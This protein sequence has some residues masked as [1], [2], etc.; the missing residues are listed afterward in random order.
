MNNQGLPV[1]AVQWVESVLGDGAKVT[2]VAKMVGGI[3]AGIHRVEIEYD[4][5]LTSYVLRR[6]L[7]QEWLDK[8]PDLARHEAESLRTAFQGG[9][10]APDLIAYDEYGLQ[11]GSPVVLSSFLPGKVILQPEDM[12]DWLSGLAM[13][14]MQ[15]HQA[16]IPAFPWRYYTYNNVQELVVPSWT[17]RTED[18]EKALEI[19]RGPRPDGPE[20]FIHRDFHPTN[21]LWQNGKVSG[22]VD[23]V[24]ACWGPVGIDLGH[25]RLNLVHLY[26][27]DVADRFLSAYQNLTSGYIQHAYWDLIT[28]VEFLPGP[29]GMYPG[30]TDLG[31][32]DIPEKI[33][34]ER[35]DEYLVSIMK[36]K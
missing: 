23:W 27:V 6:F 33:L 3:G 26:G 8:E 9:L 22:L 13:L 15:I 17:G 4:G 25:C 24:N 30:W 1:E 10:P 11:S 2:G 31:F 5:E 29:L 12:G 14:A 18:W 16:D 21:V 32:P 36:R 20:I 34:I 19:V 7:N 28:L 35:M